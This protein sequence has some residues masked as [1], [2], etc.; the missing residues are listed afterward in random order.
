MEAGLPEIDHYQ[1]VSLDSKP[2]LPYGLAQG[3]WKPQAPA[4]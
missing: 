3:K 4:Y 2:A 1:I